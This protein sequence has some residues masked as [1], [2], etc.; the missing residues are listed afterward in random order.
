MDLGLLKKLF[1][2]DQHWVGACTVILDAEA[3]VQAV[4]ADALGAGGM[5]NWAPRTISGRIT[6]DAVCMLRDCS[7]IVL[8][9]TTRTKTATGEEQIKH[10]LALADPAHVVGV[11]YLDG[12]PQVL[13]T[14]GLEMPLSRTGPK[15][16]SS[17]TAKPVA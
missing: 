8:L 7:A 17:G 11:E 14:L 6:A 2:T 4:G 15:P 1:G 10:S 13:A 16:I 5:K 12:V 3:T 9:Q